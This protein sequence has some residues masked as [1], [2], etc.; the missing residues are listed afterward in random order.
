MSRH[1]VFTPWQF[2]N[3]CFMVIFVLMFTQAIKKVVFGKA[4]RS[5][6]RYFITPALFFR[7]PVEA[8]FD[9]LAGITVVGLSATLLMLMRLVLAS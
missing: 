2:L 3:Q 9:S 8:G 5:G 6:F 1:G 4:G 7:Q